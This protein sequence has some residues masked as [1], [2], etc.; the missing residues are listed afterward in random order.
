MPPQIKFLSPKVFKATPEDDAF[1]W[2]ER[3]ESTG[4]YNQWGDTELRANFSMYLDGAARKWYLCSTLP[5]E[6]RDL[7]IRPGVGPN[8]ADLPAVTGVRTLFLK[9]T[10][11]QNYKLFKEK[12]LRNRVQGIEEATTNYYYDVI[13]LCRVVDPTMAEATTSRIPVWGITALV[14]RKIV[15]VTTKDRRRILR[16]GEMVYGCQALGE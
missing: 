3:Y 11:Q 5:T 12:L 15:S 13:D 14:G 7:P 10:Q 6:W 16:G 2:L 9:E 8:A 4:A 1:D